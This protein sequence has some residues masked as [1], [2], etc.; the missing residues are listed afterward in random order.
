MAF[1]STFAME[2]TY[3]ADTDWFILW[4]GHLESRVWSE[5]NG[6]VF[7]CWW[8]GMER[9]TGER[10]TSTSAR[11][12]AED[13][14]LAYHPQ[15]KA[16]KPAIKPRNIVEPASKEAVYDFSDDVGGVGSVSMWEELIT[17]GGI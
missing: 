11:L 17:G 6:W 16:R 5:G 8:H 1:R 10:A 14:L 15:R 7:K 12:A 2:W 13:Y 4:K 3:Y 9:E